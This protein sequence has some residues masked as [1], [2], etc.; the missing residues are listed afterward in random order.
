[1]KKLIKVA[2]IASIGILTVVATPVHQTRAIPTDVDARENVAKIVSDMEVMMTRS[3]TNEAEDIAKLAEKGYDYDLTTQS[4]YSQGLPYSDYQYLEFIAAY[5]TIQNYCF[6]NGI[7]MGDGINNI[8]F[9]NM[10]YEDAIETEYVSKKVDKYV[11]NEDGTFKKSG[12]TYI[13][14]PCDIPAYQIDKDG[15]YVKKGTEHI[16]L[17]TVDTKYAE[18]TLST[19]GVED[20]YRA[21]GLEREDFREEEDQRLAKLEEIMGEGEVGQTIFIENST[22]MTEEQKQIIDESLTLA[23][24]N[25]QKQIISIASSIIGKVP[26]EWGGK[27]DKAGFDETWYTFDDSGRQKGLDC[28]GYVQWVLRTANI[29]GWK[30]LGSTAAD[31]TSK[32]LQIISSEELLPGDLGFFYPAGTDKVNHVGIY[33]GNG[34]WIHCSS[35]ANSVTVSNNIGFAVFR[36]FLDVSTNQQLADVELAG[37]EIPADKIVDDNVMLMAKIVQCEAQTEGYNGWV[38][39]AQVIRNRILSPNF[40]GNDVLSVVGA[41]GQFATY[42]K[43]SRMSDGEVN[44]DIL[45]VCEQVLDGTLKYYDD[46]VIGFK[47]NDGDEYW[48]GWHRYDILG[49]HAFYKLR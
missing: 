20:V 44:V 14:E 11:Q 1:M 22:L 43:A 34:K 9:V 38:A 41:S 6:K 2:A 47:V 4:F 30:D 31:L 8:D 15:N 12:Y 36:R 29:D 40:K 33:L 39:V 42:A 46:E 7:S 16:D 28:S 48:N 18:I 35:T 17:E 5:T 27:S 26:Y 24:T 21:F 32:R 37:A 10:T 25:Q 19:I 49:N 23:E 45:H 13:T 3:Y